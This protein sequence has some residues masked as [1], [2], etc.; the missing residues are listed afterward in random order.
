MGVVLEELK[1][2]LEREV[3]EHGIAVWFDPK[4][5]YEAALEDLS[6][7]GITLLR[8]EGS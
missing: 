3:R 6:L 1:R 7:A 8:Y 4:R 2:L 5:H